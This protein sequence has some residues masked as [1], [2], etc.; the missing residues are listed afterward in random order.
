MTGFQGL[1]GMAYIW[2]IDTDFV[3]L[4]A[5]EDVALLHLFDEPWRALKLE[6]R[7]RKNTRNLVAL[8][9]GKSQA[10]LALE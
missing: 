9:P 2:S 3:V 8:M 7:R 5:E 4:P 6:Q 1:E 10:A